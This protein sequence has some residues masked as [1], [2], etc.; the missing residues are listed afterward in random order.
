MNLELQTG[1][2]TLIAGGMGALPLAWAIGRWGIGVEIR[3]FGDGNPGAMNVLRAG[4]WKWFVPALLLE[5]LKGA[6]P[7]ALARWLGGLS[8]WA[9][10]LPALA[11]PLGHAFT[12][13]LRFR[14]G[15]G[16]AVTF[17]VWC[18]LTEWRVPILLGGLFAV[19]LRLF[20]SEEQAVRA[21]M[22]ALDLL[23]G[24]AALIGF[25]S[26][27]LWAVALGHTLLLLWTHRRTT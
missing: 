20:R 21:G 3:S 14:G 16:L 9:L 4:G 5:F 18:G 24:G 12:P 1:L 25:A 26:V 23:L 7:I 19:A 10:V 13:W 6:L 22:L 27:S 11:A 8:G 2:W 15:K 17:G